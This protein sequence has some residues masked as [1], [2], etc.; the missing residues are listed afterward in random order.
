MGS[1]TSAQKQAVYRA[2]AD[3]EIPLCEVPER[4]RRIGPQ[5]SPSL[6]TYVVATLV[7]VLIAFAA[8]SACAE[9]A[10]PRNTREAA[11]MA[12]QGRIL[13]SAEAGCRPGYLIEGDCG[14]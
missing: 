2:Y 10:P 12:E 13:V 7:A 8:E 9:E 11:A 3:G 4:I 5:P 1:G 6:A 14:P